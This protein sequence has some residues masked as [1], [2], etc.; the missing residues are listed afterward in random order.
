MIPES[1]AADYTPADAAV[2]VDRA[3]EL[4]A[5]MANA[6]VEAVQADDP[7]TAVTAHLREYGTIIGHMDGADVRIIALIVPMVAASVWAET[8]TSDDESFGHIMFNVKAKVR[9]W[10]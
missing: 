7:T 9:D 8:V 3:V 4:V 6:Y 5:R 1:P 10:L 2:D